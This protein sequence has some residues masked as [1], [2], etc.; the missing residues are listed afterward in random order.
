MMAIQKYVN[1]DRHGTKHSEKASKSPT[2]GGCGTLAAREFLQR[3]NKV[4]GK[5]KR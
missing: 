5:R 1:I 2:P 4:H 3:S